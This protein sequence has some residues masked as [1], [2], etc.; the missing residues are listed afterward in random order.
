MALCW[1]QPQLLECDWVT[2]IV[3]KQAGMQNNNNITALMRFYSSS[4]LKIEHFENNNFKM[5]LDKEINIHDKY[6]NTFLM[7][8][9]QSNPNLLNHDIFTTMF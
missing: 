1:F 2:N 8:L 3:V 5:L 7:Y 9:C 6:N 4:N